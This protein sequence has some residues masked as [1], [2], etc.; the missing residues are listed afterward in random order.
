MN[1]VGVHLN[2][3]VAAAPHRYGTPSHS[4]TAASLAMNLLRCTTNNITA[5][6]ILSHGTSIN[7]VDS[8]P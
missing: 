1:A 8:D 2:L 3:G 7:C 6:I 4:S 5:Y